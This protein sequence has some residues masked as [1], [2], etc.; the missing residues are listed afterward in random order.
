LVL[1]ITQSA[2]YAQPFHHKKFH[3]LPAI[4]LL[5]KL[6]Y[7]KA[8]QKCGLKENCAVP[9]VSSIFGIRCFPREIVWVP[10]RFWELLHLY[11]QVL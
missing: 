4:A 6:Q 11:I 9:K 2:K 7:C 10:S 8:L 1:N 5:G 3:T